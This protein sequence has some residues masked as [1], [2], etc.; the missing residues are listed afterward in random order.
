MLL[1]AE[2]IALF[3]T[4]P[5]SLKLQF[6][7][8]TKICIFKKKKSNCLFKWSINNENVERVDEFWYLGMKCYY[9]GNLSN[10]VKA[11]N[12]QALRAYDQLLHVF[13]RISC[14]VKTKLALF[15]SLV[16]PIILY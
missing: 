11:L 14:D 7:A 1:F 6:N 16:V 12:D 3:T 2:D 5:E 15:D 4:N 13:S 9:T 10:A 8:I